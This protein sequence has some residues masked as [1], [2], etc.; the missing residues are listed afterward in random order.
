M[1]KKIILEATGHPD[2]LDQQGESYGIEQFGVRYPD[3]TTHWTTT[4]APG[5]NNLYEKEDRERL[6]HEYEALLKNKH[7]VKAGE[8][9][10][11]KRIMYVK[12]GP[13]EELIGVG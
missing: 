5:G 3:G 11:L 10:F 7:L 13:V 12:Y 9:T 4:W 8:I 1:A 2:T 6:L